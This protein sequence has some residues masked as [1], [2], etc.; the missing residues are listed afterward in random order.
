[1]RILID[2]GHP[3][4]VHLLK[5]V[6]KNLE[7]DGHRVFYSVRDIPVA[8]RLMD[9]Y[10][11]PYYD[12][13]K[14]SDSILGKA[15]TVIEQDVKL[16]WFVIKHKI[17]I[18]LSSGIALPHVSCL[19]TMKS[20]VF[21]DDDDEVEPFVVKY[22]HPFSDVVLSPSALIGHRKNGKAVF[23][24][25]YH[26]L[27]YLH[28]NVFSPDRSTLDRLGIKNGERY[29]VL[30]FVALK[31]HHDIG[32]KGLSFEQKMTLVNILKGYGR[33]I[34]TAERQ[35]EPEL[36]PY[37]LAVPAEDMHSVLAFASLFI[38]DSQTMASEAAVLGVPSLRCNTFCGRISYLNEEEH[39]Y[40][41]T[42]AYTPDQFEKL[43][44]K[45]KELL[46]TPAIKEELAFKRQKLLKD[47]IDVSAFFTW[48]IEN[49]PESR[50][51]MRE[52]PDYQYR[53]R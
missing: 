40:N 50:R 4:H 41:L 35:L 23:Y 39:Q 29:F 19:T 12:L 22:C 5:N 36:E 45:L 14:K 52:N 6:A 53:F 47:K 46:D 32:N 44:V 18:G 30:R 33:V 27:A 49:Y 48:F 31:G 24:A 43:I 10:G 16:L 17:D 2:I 8:K 42:Y 13:G 37:R 28:P 25:G 11:M 20:F 1:M 26:E 3:G 21:D 7:K 34:I 9:T 38:G 51:I 15:W